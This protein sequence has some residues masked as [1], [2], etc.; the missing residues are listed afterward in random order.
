[1]CLVSPLCPAIRCTETGE[2]YG[3]KATKNKARAAVSGRAAHMMS[4]VDTS[5]KGGPAH[6][7]EKRD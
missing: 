6:W 5:D 3:D 4:E 1:M 7:V 2:A